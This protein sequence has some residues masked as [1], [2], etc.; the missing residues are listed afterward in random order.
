MPGLITATFVFT[1]LVGSTALGS[2]LGPVGAEEIR[3]VHFGLL[4]GAVEAT[5]GTEVKN[6]GDGLMVM[7]TSAG[8]ALSCAVAMQ[9][10][11]EAHNRR[12]DVPLSIR[13]GVSAGEATEEDGDYFGDPVIEAA[14][15]CAMAGDDQILATGM[16]TALVGRGATQVFRP[17]GELA[18]KGIPEPVPCVEVRWEPEA[19]GADALVLPSR[20][21]GVVSNATL[22]FVGR[23]SE[24][25][26]INAAVRT[27]ESGRSPQLVTIAGEP[28]MGKTTLAA[29]VASGLH[30]QGATVVFGRCDEGLGVPFRPWIEALEHLVA[31]LPDDVVAA[32]VAERGDALAR[33]IPALSSDRDTGRWMAASS[34]AESDRFVLF[35]A[36]ADL[37][38]R[39]GSDRLVVVILDD[40]Q[41]ADAASLQLLAHVLTIGVD[42]PVTVIATYR[43]SDL[44]RGDRLSTF[45]ADA[46]RE[47]NVTRIDLAGFGD[48]EMVSLMESAAGHELTESG[49]ALAR[50]LHRETKGNPFFTGEM[51]R[52]LASSGAIAQGASGRFELHQTI[53]EMGLP[54]SVREVVGRRVDRLGD[55]AVSVLGA[56]A[57]IGLS[58]DLDV[59][60]ELVD[61]DEDAVLDVLEA[62]M[63]A[64]LVQD[65][66]DVVGRCNFSH[67][68]VRQTLAQDL[69]PIRRQRIHRHIAEVLETRVGTSPAELAVHFIAATRPTNADKG[70]RYATLA[71]DA[72][73]D[74]L[75]AEDAAS[76]FTQALELH[77]ARPNSDEG[78]RCDLLIKLGTAQRDARDPAFRDTLLDAAASADRLEDPYRYVTAALA[79]T[80]GGSLSI[81]ADPE[82]LAVITRAAELV[83]DDNLEHRVMLL[84]AFASETDLASAKEPRELAAQ[85]L[86]LAR[87]SG[88]DQLVLSVLAATF[89]VDAGPTAHERWLGDTE[90][91]MTAAANQDD[92]S[93]EFWITIARIRVLGEAGRTDDYE[94][95]IAHA[96]QL[97]GDTGTPRLFNALRHPTTASMAQRAELVDAE[98]LATDSYVRER[99]LPNALIRY[100]SQLFVIRLLQGRL[101]E[102][103]DLFVDATERTSGVAT[104]QAAT[105]YMLCDLGR[106]DEAR[107]AFPF[108]RESIEGFPDDFAWTVGVKCVAHCI[109]ALGEAD[110]AEVLYDKMFPHRHLF[111]NSFFILTGSLEQNLGQLAATMGRLDLAIDHLRAGVHANESAR[112][113]YW[114]AETQLD[115][116]DALGQRHRPADLE[117]RTALI[118]AALQCAETHGFAGLERRINT[119][120][121]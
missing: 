114:I 7:F 97:I 6:L 121:R 9:Q 85:A 90:W 111:A 11:I 63:V 53:T 84:A 33:W 47:A 19:A 87:S 74:A 112:A 83:G 72:A 24:A 68:L 109:A 81:E 52:H 115:L 18:L 70:I 41:W 96:T 113:T 43:D 35:G 40:V 110:L 69:S 100:A 93:L 58:F 119:M 23:S 31:H 22:G 82:R 5:G 104:M 39:A 108:T 61:L 38:E 106:F 116:A 49:V 79:I 78:L 29:W 107:V 67:G 42:A 91:A 88:D 8:R 80:P 26:T 27:T 25:S 21:S 15:L 98:R 102:L 10:A 28:G 64:S 48:D 37:L 66:P 120:S 60:V 14:R 1:D 2:R 92:R 65:D 36:V 32:H 4:R 95:A 99:G 45:L 73:M 62:A 12:A 101:D 76:W 77:L 105:A 71:G 86:D 75:A 51:L 3:G 56:A 44:A 20:V 94:A 16:V 89:F 118:A 13:V 57:V 50:A 59:L 55:D 103:V 117:E 30:E 34:D 17:V 46:R 54:T